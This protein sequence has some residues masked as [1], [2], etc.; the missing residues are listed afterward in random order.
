MENTMIQEVKEVSET[1]EKTTKKGNVLLIGNSGVG[2]STLINAVLGEDCAATGWGTSGTTKHIRPYEAENVP[3]RLI[4]TVGFEL[5]YFKIHAAIRE[6]QKWSEEGA[7]EGHEDNQINTIWFCV[8]GTSAKLFPKTIEH[9]TKAVKMWHSV[10]IVVV[11]TK[12][13]SKP[14]R[15]HNIEMVQHAFAQ[16]KLSANLRKIIPVVASP[17]VIDEEAAV[18]AAPDGIEE[19][20]DTTIGLLPEGITA[21]ADD[22]SAFKLSRKRAL[23]QSVVGVSTASGV[24]VGAI[25]I[26]FS[27]AVLLSGI[28]I[29]EANVIARIYGIHND[30]KSKQFFNSI[31]E[32]GTVSLA[33][34]TVIS[35]LKA[36]PGI[37]VGAAV[38]NAVIAGSIVAALGEGM[39]YAF[40][41]VYLG[42]KTVED[43][44][45][46]K[47][48]LEAKLAH[49]VVEKV[50]DVLDQISD[51]TD[52]KRN[53]QDNL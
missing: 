48:I 8:D 13:Y 4:D 40:E 25:P 42:H 45:W 1:V 30:D 32:V 15:V 33:A 19:L 35:A 36:I 10:P 23:A 53:Q 39:V 12:S 2:K 50:K 6:I 9:L 28:E 47:K 11:I 43:V 22:I 46:V 31:V 16:Q 51:T 3:F 7:K 20:I 27:D 26:P 52:K 5:S 24:V 18:F 14:D 29:A 49:S 41:Q 37:N 21:A 34:K 17:Y 38:L 44:D